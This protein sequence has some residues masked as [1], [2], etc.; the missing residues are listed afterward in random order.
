M[1]EQTPHT[2]APVFPAWY[3]TTSAAKYVVIALV[4]KESSFRAAQLRNVRPRCLLQNG[5]TRDYNA[6]VASLVPVRGFDCYSFQPSDAHD[7][8]SASIRGNVGARKE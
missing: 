2:P 7:H 5:V 1:E 3:D 6:P 4:D 8:C